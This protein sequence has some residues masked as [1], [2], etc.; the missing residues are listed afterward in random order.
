MWYGMRDQVAEPGPVLVLFKLQGEPQ[1]VSPSLRMQFVLFPRFHSIWFV[2]F[3]V[4][5]IHSLVASVDLVPIW[6]MFWIE[7]FS[8]TSAVQ[9]GYSDIVCHL[10]VSSIFAFVH[11]SCLFP[12]D[13]IQQE[14]AQ[15]GGLDWWFGALNPWLLWRVNGKPVPNLESTKLGLPRTLKDRAWLEMENQLKA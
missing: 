8:G 15:I 7:Q 3:W 1:K 12:S 4:V 10:G 5:C 2:A 9:L 13:T 14:S 11:R 6:V